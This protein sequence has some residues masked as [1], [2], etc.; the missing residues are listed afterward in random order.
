MAGS[1]VRDFMRANVPP[2]INQDQFQN[3]PVQI[4]ITYFAKDVAARRRGQ[5]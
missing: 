5:A 1:N 4:N 3:G 2:M